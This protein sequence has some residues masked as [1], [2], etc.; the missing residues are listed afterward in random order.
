MIKQLVSNI[1]IFA[2]KSKVF[3]RTS[4]LQGPCL[5]ALNT[6]EGRSHGQHFVIVAG[7]FLYYLKRYTTIHERS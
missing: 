7:R 6:Y 2:Q 4:S 1:G 3:Q 5:L